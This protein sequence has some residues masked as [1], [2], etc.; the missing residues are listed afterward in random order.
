[1]LPMATNSFRLL[2]SSI[3]SC[4]SS[5]RLLFTSITSNNLIS[6][7]LIWSLYDL[8]FQVSWIHSWIFEDNTLN[9]LHSTT[10]NPTRCLWFQHSVIE[11]SIETWVVFAKRTFRW[12]FQNLKFRVWSSDFEL[13]PRKPE[14]YLK[15]HPR[16]P[17]EIL[18]GQCSEILVAFQI[19]DALTRFIWMGNS[20]KNAN[21]KDSQFTT[22]CQRNGVLYFAWEPCA[23]VEPAQKV[24]REWKAYKN[25]LE[26]VRFRESDESERIPNVFKW[27]GS[28]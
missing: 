8:V 19:L 1:M 20:R 21:P 11:P 15:K 2:P 6:E 25:R 23:P 9:V 16:M 10:S 12:P 13:P 7:Q 22:V 28:A 5:K 14:R 27:L 26:S 4:R 24:S 3:F 17:D 18:F